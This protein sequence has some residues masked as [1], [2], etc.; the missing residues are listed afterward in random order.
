MGG[1]VTATHDSAMDGRRSPRPAAAPPVVRSRAFYV[2]I[3]L[4][5]MA[6]VLYGFWASYF[7]PLVSGGV[8]K[9]RV[10]HAHVAVFSGWMMLM[11]VQASLVAT[12]RTG[13]HR[14]LGSLGAVYGVLVLVFG[15]LATFVAPALHVQGGAWT[16]DEAAGFL[17]LPLVDMALFAGFF[18]AAIAYRNRPPI[19]KRLM[20]VATVVLI[21]P[22]IARLPFE[23][24]VTF[25]LAWLSPLFAA[26]AFDALSRRRV[27]VVYFVGTAVLATAFVRIFFMESEGWLRI[28]RG[29][30]A[31]VVSVRG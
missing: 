2:V 16:L 21:Y 18:A 7:G 1:H 30:L 6:I 17:L 29:L 23:S 20:L 31:P 15:L 19:H 5:L 12:G 24:P 10:I 28:G 27:H 3:T 11:L 9:P 13:L 14:R 22:A 26:M 8:T 25:L 4:M